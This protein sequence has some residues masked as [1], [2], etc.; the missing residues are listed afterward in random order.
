MIKKK[1]KVMLCINNQYKPSRFNFDF[2]NAL[3]SG[4]NVYKVYKK[5]QTSTNSRNKN[6]TKKKQAKCFQYMILS[7]FFLESNVFLDLFLMKFLKIVPRIWVTVYILNDTSVCLVY[8]ATY[9]MRQNLIPWRQ[10]SS[11]LIISFSQDNS[12]WSVVN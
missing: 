5:E 7:A 6:L 11:H 3:F 2:D 9:N 12:I 8:F 10:K 1:T 4:V